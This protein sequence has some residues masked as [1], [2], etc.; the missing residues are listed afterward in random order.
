METAD[1]Q[2]PPSQRRFK[3]SCGAACDHWNRYAEDYDLAQEMGVQVHRLSIEWSR[4]IPQPGVVDQAVLAHYRQMMQALHQRG[5]R[6]MLCLHH[7]T[8]PLWLADMGGF[9]N[10]KA[11][12]HYFQEY[13]DVVVPGV[14]DLVD[15]W[16]PINEPNIVPLGGY[17]TASFPPYK[18]SPRAF[19]KVYRLFFEMHAVCYH[20]IKRHFP[21]SQVGVAFAYIHTQPYNPASRLDRWTASLVDTIAN[22]RFFQG[23]RTGSMGFPLGFGGKMNGLKGTMDFV[24]LNYYTTGYMQGFKRIQARPG[25]EVNDMGQVLYPQGIYDSLQ[26]VARQID[27]PIIITEN[28]V[29]AT[30][31]SYRIRYLDAH[32]RQVARA[33]S[34]GI[35][36]QGYMVWSLTDNYEWDRGY[37]M[38]FG[39]IHVDFATQAREIKTGGRWYADVIRNNGLV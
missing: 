27:L 2:K 7:F 19:V 8:I 38:R 13:L 23:V 34:D 22:Q 35:P 26:S 17:L 37:G 1:R 29:A 30:D 15:S 31:E 25:E 4:L 24:G 36:V 3:D 12:L 10:R 11:F 9:E 32:L 20:T 6:V 33:I 18:S 21:Q 39:L 5:I 14:G 28:G 16:L